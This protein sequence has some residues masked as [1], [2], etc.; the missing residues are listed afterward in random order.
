MS[1]ALRLLAI[2]VAIVL[3]TEAGA[4]SA[5]LPGPVRGIGV[6][7][8][9]AEVEIAPGG[10]AAGPDESDIAISASSVPRSGPAASA[11]PASGPGVTSLGP[12]VTAFR[13]PRVFRHGSR[14]LPVVALTFDDG[15]SDA[16]AHLIVD[17][18][19]REH[20]PATFFING[21]WL[22]QDPAFWRSVADA[23]FVAGNHTYLHHDATTMT[24]DALVRDLQRNARVWLAVTG[25][26]MSPLFRPPYGARNAAT[27]LAAAEAGFPDVITWDAPADDTGTL[28]DAQ[29]IRSAT[30]GGSGSIV[31]MHVGPDATPRILPSVIASYRARGYS[32]V[33]VPEILPP[34]HPAPHP[35]ATPDAASALERD[36]QIAIRGP[37]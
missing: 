22:A 35:P 21:V 36:P 32:F 20:V 1:V 30:A 6:T 11:N 17:I 29:M 27:D 10:D 14:T 28:T 9:G 34:Y 15:W 8:S 16:N 12:V 24:S 37:S 4:A 25:H 31:L 5:A 7:R 33:T 3:A 13:D 19:L 18:L 23:G 2:P 26:P